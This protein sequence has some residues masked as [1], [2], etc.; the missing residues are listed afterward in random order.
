MLTRTVRFI[1]LATLLVFPAA[2]CAADE[3]GDLKARLDALEKRV[4]D[5]E[6]ALKPSQAKAS[7]E[8]IRE[9]QQI[10]AGERM[11]QDAAMFSLTQRREIETLYQV[12]NKNW[13]S[14]KAQD[15]LKTLVRK[16][17]KANRTGCA[18]LYLGQMSS[19]EEQIAYFRQAIANHSDCYYGD[20]V[21][22]GAF[23]RCL[24]G[25]TYLTSGN[26]EKAA[27]LFEEIR[28]DYPDSI[29]HN[30]RLLVE[31]LPSPKA[32]ER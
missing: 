6:K 8:Q 24:L 26:A 19:G 11:R 30:G 29:D 16:Y 7:P 15:A 1:A 5:L 27:T 22:V 10:K 2:V 17:K 3:S 28:K 21:Q 14:E 13:R 20:G 12:A 9:D 32:E 4:E 18:I 31:Q 25:K 23:A